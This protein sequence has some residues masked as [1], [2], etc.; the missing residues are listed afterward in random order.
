MNNRNRGDGLPRVAMP[1]APPGVE[2]ERRR[3]ARR[4]V[5]GHAVDVNDCREL[6]AMLGLLSEEP[7]HDV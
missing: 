7:P 1:P 6:L 2:R 4:A 3:L 5:A